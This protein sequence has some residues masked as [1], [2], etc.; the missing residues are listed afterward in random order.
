MVKQK[1]YALNG[2]REV[3]WDAFLIKEQSG[4]EIRMHQPVRREKVFTLDHVWEGNVSGYFALMKVGEIYRLYYRA[5][6]QV[7][8]ADGSRV[9]TIPSI[10]LA[11]SKDCRCFK[12]VPV[13]KHDYN[14]ISTNNIVYYPGYYVDN[15]SVFYDENPA[16]LPE[17]KY[18]ALCMCGGANAP[19]PGLEHGLGLFV[20]EDGIDFTFKRRLDIP[21]EFDSYNVLVWDKYDQIYRIYY[22][23]ERRPEH[24]EFDV[25]KK[26]RA[27]F[28]TVSLA[29]SKDL[30][31]FELYGELDYGQASRDIQLYTNQ[32]TKYAR[33]DHMYIGFPGRYID[34]WEDESNFEQMPLAERHKYITELYGREG[35]VATDC[36]IMISRDGYHFERRDEAYM[37]PGVENRNNWWYGDCYNVYGLA[38]TEADEEGAPNEISFLMPENYRIKDVEVYRYTTRLDGFFSWYAGF[39]GGEVL[40]KPFLFEGDELEINFATSALG[41]IRIR[42]CDESGNPLEGFDSGII[43]GDSVDRKV[44]FAGE[45]KELA[46]KA[47]RM[48]VQLKDCHLYSFRFQ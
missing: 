18:K 40:T 24:E 48:K 32:I 26:S 1:A 31:S 36:G 47:I 6:N 28:R 45:L 15:F 5:S 2:R 44:R 42:L 37:T 22:R 25:I 4:V 35:T 3:C 43:F 23:D 7:E 11:E 30:V 16:C 8:W 46:G 41:S 27:V 12:R 33:A 39:K 17:E 10:C 29:T 21:G 9:S 20:S 34:R 19:V 13:N 14:G 38:E